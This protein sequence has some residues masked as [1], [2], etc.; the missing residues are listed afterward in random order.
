MT[1]GQ[2]CLSDIRNEKLK[3]THA[4]TNH[5]TSPNNWRIFFYKKSDGHTSH[6]MVLNWNHLHVYRWRRLQSAN[7]DMENISN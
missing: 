2:G 4:K 3:E 7:R 1:T 5:R 6:S